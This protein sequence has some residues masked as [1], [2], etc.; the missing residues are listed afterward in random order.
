MIISSVF[1]LGGLGLVYYMIKESLKIS[2]YDIKYELNEDELVIHNK[3]GVFSYSYD[4][5]EDLDYICPDETMQLDVITFKIKQT[6][7]AISMIGKKE[8]A[9]EFFR[10]LE[11]RSG[12]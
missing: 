1:V 12:K 4:Q 5:I 2:A 10:Y 3:K 11:K 8:F 9:E 7:Y 6:P